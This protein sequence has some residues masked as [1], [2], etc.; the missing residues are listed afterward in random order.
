MKSL[1]III[2]ILFPLSVK[3]SSIHA[4]E[5]DF[6]D[7]YNY[8]FTVSELNPLDDL[9]F[10]LL[11]QN[12]GFTSVGIAQSKVITIEGVKYL[13]VL[14]TVSAD[15]NLT[16]TDV[17]CTGSCTIPFTLEASYAN[18]GADNIG[19]A[20]TMT[21]LANVANAQFPILKRTSGPA[22]P[23]PTPVF[24][25][26]NPAVFNETAYLYVYG[27]LNVGMVNAG[28]YSG[29]VTVSISYD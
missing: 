27:S 22:G 16:N 23:P 4:Q 19:Q 18:L 6:G 25:G 14:V 9:D 10:G 21:V 8:S 7:F 17:G 11:V 24:E 15:N 5:I 26:F 12:Q 20:T 2:F 1:T 29:V 13:D 28:S 3:Q